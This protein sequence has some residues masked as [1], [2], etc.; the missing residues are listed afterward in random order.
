MEALRLFIEADSAGIQGDWVTVDRNIGLL[1]DRGWRDEGL[2]RSVEAFWLAVRGRYDEAAAALAQA[3]EIPEWHI[4][5][6]LGGDAGYGLM[7]TAQVRIYR[8]T[9]R[10]PEADRLASGLL[11]RFRKELESV[12]KGCSLRGR[13]YDNWMRYASLAASEGLEEEAVTALGGAMRC[14]DLPPGFLPQLPWFRAL[15]G[16]APYEALKRER[17][18]RIERIRPE[19]LRIESEAGLKTVAVDSG[20]PS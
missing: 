19:L 5:P 1:R 16:Y 7:E 9:G 2:I 11:E 13:R 6:V 17:E 4:P 15:D 14:G 12:G 18:A 10:K 3:G 8:E 20:S